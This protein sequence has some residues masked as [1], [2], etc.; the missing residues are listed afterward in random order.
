LARRPAKYNIS[1]AVF[2]AGQIIFNA[3]FKNINKRE[4][5]LVCHYGVSII[6]D[7]TQDLDTSALGTKGHSPCARKEIYGAHIP[8][9]FLP[10]RVI[11]AIH[12][13]I[14]FC[15]MNKI[16]VF[17]KHWY[18]SIEFAK[19]RQHYLTHLWV[20][21][22]VAS[23]QKDVSPFPDIAC[24]YNFGFKTIGQ[25]APRLLRCGPFSD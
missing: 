24:Y 18:T 17:E 6:F 19:Q 1:S 5:P 20:R 25:H 11:I 21:S 23:Q 13:R 15:L 3:I 14:N 2:F 10:V 22:F 12:A 16:Q 7:S 8:L 9:R 4:V